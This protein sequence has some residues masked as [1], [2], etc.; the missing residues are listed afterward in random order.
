MRDAKGQASA[1]CGLL[2]SAGFATRAEAGTWAR[3]SRPI[4]RPRPAPPCRLHLGHRLI[5]GIRTHGPS[6]KAD[7]PAGFHRQR[8][9][10]TEP[11]EHGEVCG[12]ATAAAGAGGGGALRSRHGTSVSATAPSSCARRRTRRPRSAPSTS[13]LARKPSWHCGEREP[14]PG[15][16][17]EDGGLGG[18]SGGPGRGNGTSSA[19]RRCTAR[20]SP[21]RQ[22]SGLG[23]VTTPRRNVGCSGWFF[24]I[25]GQL[26]PGELRAGTW[27]GHYAARFRTVELNA[28]FYSW[29]TLATVKSW[30]RQCDNRPSSTPSGQRAD[31]PHQ[32]LR[33]NATS[34]S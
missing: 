30:L 18:T 16:S 29:P 23:P 26:L 24:G 9:G 13:C 33:G 4:R 6:G 28:P 2:S 34:G 11:V 21:S 8:S 1:H 12:M 27:F 3:Y 19:P 17:P 31:H 32:G 15:S 14:V 20:A 7:R 25:G 5:R 10:R 22:R